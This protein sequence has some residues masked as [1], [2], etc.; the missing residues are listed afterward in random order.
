MVAGIA[1]LDV[2]EPELEPVPRDE[3]PAGLVAMR[4]RSQA[5]VANVTKRMHPGS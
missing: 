1:A 4:R 2:N 3:V 5:D